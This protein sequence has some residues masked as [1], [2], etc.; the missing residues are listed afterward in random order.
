MDALEELPELE[1]QIVQG[2]LTLT[3]LSQ[4]QNFCEQNE[5]TLKEKREI[6]AQVSGLS[7]RDT[8]RKLAKISPMPE[9]PEKVRP[10]DQELTEIRITLGSETLAAL[11]KIKDL[12]AHAHP[13]AS[14]AEVIAYLAKLGLMKLDPA[15]KVESKPQAVFKTEASQLQAGSTP[16]LVPHRSLGTPHSIS[17]TQ[18]GSCSFPPGEKSS[19]QTRAAQPIPINVRQA[20]PAATRREVWRRDQGR[21][22]YASPETGRICGATAFVQ[23]DHITPRALGGSNDANNLRLRCQAHNILAAVEVLGSQRMAKYVRR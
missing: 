10:L 1:S 23:I 2:T 16:V 5:K 4:V 20:V 19:P 21:C 22:G 8:E 7:K 3:N 15:T 17:I 13:G 14:Y 9:R 6:L 11:D 18:T 12:I